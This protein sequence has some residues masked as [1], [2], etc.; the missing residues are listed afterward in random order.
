[1]NRILMDN[2]LGVQELARLIGKSVTSIRRYTAAGII[3]D[4]RDPVSRRRRWTSEQAW[5]IREALKPQEQVGVRTTGVG[6]P[7]SLLCK[8]GFKWD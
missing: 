1:M 5:R 4:T 6:L 8:R 3:P 2:Y 7:S